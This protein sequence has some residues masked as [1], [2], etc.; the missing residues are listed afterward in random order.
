MRRRI[1]LP[2]Y[3]DN[4]FLWLGLLAGAA[5]ALLVVGSSALSEARL[6]D[7]TIH[8]EFAQAAGLRAGATVDVSGIEVGAVRAVRLVGDKVV[9][10]L[11]VRRDLRLGPDARAAIKMS[12]ILGRLHVELV[13]GNG[14]GLPDDTI[15]LAN[16]AVPYNLA[17]VIQDPVYTSSFERIERIDPEKLRQ[18]LDTL[19]RQMGDSP[20]LTIAALDSIGALAKVIN[21]RRDEV[22]SLLKGLDQVSQLVA[23][24]QNSVLL[25]LTRGE[26]IGEAVALRQ[27]L[28]RQLLDNVAALSG[29]LQEMGLENEGQLG[30][31]I[32]NLN[33]MT[34]GLE[35]NR[36]NLDRLYEIMPVTI[37]QFNNALGNGPYGEVWAPWVFPDNWLCFAQAVPGCN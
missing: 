32:Q 4:R 31:L 24:N 26:A 13:P 20:Q 6:A 23:D 25:L 1:P 10:D 30:P 15:R 36:E 2:R 3:A 27:D 5:V 11:R 29:L 28:L 8:A 9:A 37:R 21:E 22:D 19:E 16:T 34:E 35:K 12:T 14:K 7:K 18:A 17:K 33:T